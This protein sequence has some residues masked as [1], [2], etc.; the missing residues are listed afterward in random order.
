MIKKI[1]NGIWIV[2]MT[3]IT[4]WITSIAYG[5]S[6]Q[7]ITTKNWWKIVTW[8]YY[9][10]WYYWGQYAFDLQKKM[11]KLGFSENDTVIIINNCKKQEKLGKIKNVGQCIRTSGMIWYAESSGWEHCYNN[12]CMWLYAG[13]KAY[14]NK[15]KMFKDWISR[16]VKY[17][18]NHPYPNEYYGRNPK[19]RY[20][21]GGCYDWLKNSWRAYN[22]LNSNK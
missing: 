3:C 6:I 8:K 12:N 1:Y 22:I 18:Y 16:Y 7:K 10:R 4:L 13:N 20:C 17:W 15:D 11:F 21:Y 9:V 19:T 5:L 2:A 14:K